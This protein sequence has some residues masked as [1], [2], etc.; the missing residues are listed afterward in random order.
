MPAKITRILSPVFFALVVVLLGAFYVSGGK[1]SDRPPIFTG[2]KKYS[3]G[4]DWLSYECPGVDSRISAFRPI[5]LKLPEEPRWLLTGIDLYRRSASG[6]LF[7]EYLPIEP[8]AHPSF[9]NIYGSGSSESLNLLSADVNFDG[10]KDLSL[11]DKLNSRPEDERRRWWLFDVVSGTFKENELSAI[12]NSLGEVDIYTDKKTVGS[13]KKK[14]ANEI[15]CDFL[16]I[17]GN[18]VVSKWKDSCLRDADDENFFNYK[19]WITRNGGPV[20]RY[21]LIS[22][23]DCLNNLSDFEMK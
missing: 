6:L 10:E 8:S 4:G 11:N 14:S 12:L 3:A 13:C 18:E 9:R 7:L 17:K 2:C 21:D 5:F 20:I 15:T 16:K 19:R 1:N 23:E 22:E